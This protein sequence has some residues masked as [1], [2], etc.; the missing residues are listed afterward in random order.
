MENIYKVKFI[1]QKFL[2]LISLSK[3]LSRVIVFISGL[4]ILFVIPTNKLNYL[5]VRSLY[6][7]ILDVKPYSSG[8]TRAI[9]SMLHGDIIGAWEY[10]PLAY[11]VM[12]VVIFILIKDSLYLRKTK[13]FSI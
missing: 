11:L 9:S 4:I 10:N 7:T 13:D 12:T 2:F 8:I 5:P 6:E 1:L 3:P